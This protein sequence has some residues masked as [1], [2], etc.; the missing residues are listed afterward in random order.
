MVLW[1]IIRMPDKIRVSC[2]IST[3]GDADLVEKKICEILRQTIFDQVEFLFV[4]TGSPERERDLIA[5]YAEKYSNIRLVTTDER[6][7]LYEAW[8]LGWEAARAEVLCY[9]NMDDALHP[10]C[11]ERVAETM[12]ARPEV[13]MCSVMIAYQNESSPGVADSFDLERL[14]KLKIGRRAGPFS[15]WRKNLSQTMGM[16]DGHYRIIGDMDFWSRAADA[17]LNA[18]LIRKVLYLYTTA[19]SQLSKRES[20]KPERTYAAEKGVRLRWHPKLARATLFHRKIFRMFP[21]PYLVL[22]KK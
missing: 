2:I 6:R 14:R 11:L 3:Y 10:E 16:F 19:P 1:L 8:N 15:A 20:K 17:Q 18:V 4:E 21:T 13:D 9:S 5:P 22:E 12:E 7:T